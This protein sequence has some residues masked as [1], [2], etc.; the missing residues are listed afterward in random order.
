MLRKKASL[1]FRLSLIGSILIFINGIWI[2]QNA[3]PIVLTTDSSL[4]TVDAVNK[5]SA[6][7]GR[8]SL[9]NKGMVEGLWTP[10]WLLFTIALFCC[11]IEI[12]RKPRRHKNLGFLIVIFSLFGLPIGGGFL[13]GSLLAFIG[14]ML[15][16]EWPK[17]FG[18]TFI[19]RTVRAARLDSKLATELFNDP[20]AIRSGIQV[21][22]LTSVLMGLGNAIYVLNANIIETQP[23]AAYDILFLGKLNM[24]TITIANAFSFIGIIFLRWL[25]LSTILYIIVA[26]LKCRTVDFSKLSCV[27]AFAF[28]PLCLQLLLPILVP[29]KPYLVNWSLTINLLS[30][31][32]VAIAVVVLIRGMT[33]VTTGEALGVTIFAGVLYWVIDNFLIASN[34]L[35][36]VPGVNVKFNPAS[37]NTII[38][39]MS[40]A[41]LLAILLG[42]FATEK[43]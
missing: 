38:L 11:T 13:I 35:I 43:K 21:L 18:E 2:F 41:I 27:T 36:S 7:W 17:P 29:S 16:L 19:G 15:A 40:I 12:Y 26:K 33:G 10:F 34:S 39:F 23:T 4:T 32:W 6:F 24:D 31:F 3:G 42:A 5:A 25:I 37:S 1:A 30:T 28:V 22:V 20:K 14:G 9:G 8:I